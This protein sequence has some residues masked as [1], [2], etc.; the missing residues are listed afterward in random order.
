MLPYASKYILIYDD[1]T[2]YETQKQSN[3][4]R[5]L[6]F[7]SFFKLVLDL[8]LIAFYKHLSYNRTIQISKT[9]REI[10]KIVCIEHIERSASTAY[11]VF[12]S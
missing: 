9:K 8:G 2:T 7:V 10:S 1:V 12:S 4:I 5:K 11:C 3:K 6:I